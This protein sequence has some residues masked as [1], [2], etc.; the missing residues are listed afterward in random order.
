MKNAVF[1]DVAPSRSCMNSRLGG[2]SVHTRSTRCHI[3]VDG[4]LQLFFCSCEATMR[5][6][7]IETD[8][9]DKIMYVECVLPTSLIL[10]LYNAPK[11]ES[12]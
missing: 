3:P 4:I 8:C 7:S 11:R 5:L 2:T 1:W 6:I 9:S 10:T 12:H